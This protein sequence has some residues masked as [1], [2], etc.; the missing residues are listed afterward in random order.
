MVRHRDRHTAH[1]GHEHVALAMPPPCGGQAEPAAPHLLAIVPCGGHHEEAGAVVVVEVDLLASACAV[2]IPA[3]LLQVAVGPR[4]LERLLAVT[5]YPASKEECGAVA[6]AVR[7]CVAVQRADVHTVRGDQG[8][9]QEDGD[10]HVLSRPVRFPPSGVLVIAV[11]APVC[12]PRHIFC[13]R[14]KLGSGLST[15]HVTCLDEDVPAPP[16]AVPPG[17]VLPDVG[18][19][20]HA[21]LVVVPPHAVLDGDEVVIRLIAVG[22]PHAGTQQPLPK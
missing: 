7:G 18:Y 14:S 22:N 4:P 12:E 9:L 17:P 15:T 20:V 6:G 3:S 8:G 16:I 10:H 19:G 2:A 5:T 13:K 21:H 11:Q 1:D